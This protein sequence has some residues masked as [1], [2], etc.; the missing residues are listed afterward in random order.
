MKV[1]EVGERASKRSHSPV[2]KRHVVS[3][4]GDGRESLGGVSREGS[5][6]QSPL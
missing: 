1:V 3:A 5:Q 2:E 6:R 4:L